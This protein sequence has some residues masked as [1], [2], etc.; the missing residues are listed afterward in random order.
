MKYVDD[1][2]RNAIL[3]DAEHDDYYH[4]QLESIASNAD[5]LMDFRGALKTNMPMLNKRSV[6]VV[7]SMLRE[8]IEYK[9]NLEELYTLILELMYKEYS[10]D[11]SISPRI[12]QILKKIKGEDIKV[13]EDI[14]ANTDAE[15]V[16]SV[17]I[18]VCALYSNYWDFS[19]LPIVRV[20]EYLERVFDC[21]DKNKRCDELRCSIETNLLPL[22]DCEEYKHYLARFHR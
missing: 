8:L 3:E 20:N 6:L 12:V 18:S 2:F 21:F 10:Y 5:L 9:A 4:V 17:C 22:L 1:F 15:N 19:E 7:V 14:T 11:W 16:V 13:F